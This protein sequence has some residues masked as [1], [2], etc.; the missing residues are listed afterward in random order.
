MF[1][2]LSRLNLEITNPQIN[3]IMLTNPKK[4]TIITVT[5]NLDVLRDGDAEQC[6]AICSNC[7][8]ATNFSDNR[9]GTGKGNAMESKV[10]K[11]KRVFWIGDLENSTGENDFIDILAVAKK[12]PDQDSLLEKD[13]YLGD[14]GVVEAFVEKTGGPNLTKAEENAANQVNGALEM[15][16]SISFLVGFQDGARMNYRICTIDP[17]IRM[18]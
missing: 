17:K 10:D 4:N 1:T 11:G 16:Y 13:F 9:G 6:E 3:T 12:D 8:D 14:N 18:A 2:G 15:D 5:V 7:Y